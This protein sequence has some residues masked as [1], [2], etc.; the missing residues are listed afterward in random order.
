MEPI[1]AMG[2]H[3]RELLEERERMR[4]VLADYK[5]GRLPRRE[6]PTDA[7]TYY[8]RI[9]QADAEI[10]RYVG[11]PERDRLAAEEASRILRL[12]EQTIER[13]E[14]LE[15]LLDTERGHIQDTTNLSTPLS[16]R[17]AAETVAWREGITRKE[18]PM[19]E[20]EQ[21]IWRD[22]LG[23][24]AREIAAGWR[25]AEVTTAL[26]TSAA[27]NYWRGRAEEFNAR[28]EAIVRHHPELVKDL[29][30]ALEIDEIQVRQQ[31]LEQEHSEAKSLAVKP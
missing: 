20:R 5:T 25:A 22:T 17:L 26:E 7:H 24:R 9:Q 16:W 15:H 4:R 13:R 31:V 30:P 14:R 11:G 3:L 8:G 21:A 18:P 10:E 6:V 28:R 12:N 23:Q 2:E 27:L 29:P 1:Q 19:I